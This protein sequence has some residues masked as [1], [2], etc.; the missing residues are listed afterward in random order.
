MDITLCEMLINNLLKNAFV[1]NTKNGEIIIKIDKNKTVFCNTGTAFALNQTQ[2]FNYFYK[3]TKN[4]NSTGLG[5]VLVKT[6]C[7]KN[8]LDVDYQFID[9]KH[10]F[11]IAKR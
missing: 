8:N 1:H 3:E 2:I 7:K 4:E 11:I 10:Q 6:I 5:L 9:N